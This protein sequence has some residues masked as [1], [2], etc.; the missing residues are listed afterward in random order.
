MGKI[1]RMICR[2]ELVHFIYS[3]VKINASKWGIILYDSIQKR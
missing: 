3:S 2:L 1:K